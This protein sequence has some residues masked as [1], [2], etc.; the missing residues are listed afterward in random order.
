MAA[1]ALAQRRGSALPPPM[2]LLQ[3]GAGSDHGRELAVNHVR[4]HPGWRLS[5]QTHKWLGLR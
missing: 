1:A 2:L 4:R 5:L 3:P